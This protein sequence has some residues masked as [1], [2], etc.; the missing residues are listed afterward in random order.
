MRLGSVLDQ[1][2]ELSKALQNREAILLSF[3]ALPPF[4]S[5]FF[6]LRLCRILVVHKALQF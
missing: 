1:L 5:L 3:I 6:P 4:W 2:S